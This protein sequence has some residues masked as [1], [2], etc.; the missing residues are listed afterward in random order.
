MHIPTVNIH[1]L[2]MA[3]KVMEAQYIEKDVALHHRRVEEYRMFNS[4][5]KRQL[6]YH[7][8]RIRNEKS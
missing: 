3:H 8:G 1:L 5:A 2:K 6:E 7:K 4:A